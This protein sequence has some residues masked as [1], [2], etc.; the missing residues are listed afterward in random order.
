[1]ATPAPSPG[2]GLSHH[3]GDTRVSWGCATGGP[4]VVKQI[5]GGG[6][7][8]SIMDPFSLRCQLYI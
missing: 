6:G 5:G 1:M 7:Q 3:P 4:A 2:F 8:A